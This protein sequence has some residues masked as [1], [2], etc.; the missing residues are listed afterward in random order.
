MVSIKLGL[1]EPTCAASFQEN[2]FVHIPLIIFLGN[3]AKKKK[4]CQEKNN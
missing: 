2:Y 1:M 3:V 4:R